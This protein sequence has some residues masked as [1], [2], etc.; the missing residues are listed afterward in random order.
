MNFISNQQSR[1]EQQREHG[2]RGQT[3]T[4]NIFA[5]GKSI[6]SAAATNKKVEM[7]HFLGIFQH[8]LA[9]GNVACA[10]TLVNNQNCNIKSRSQLSG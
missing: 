4:M 5:D 8:F 1:H 3:A 2:T 7:R 9:A 10:L 6:S